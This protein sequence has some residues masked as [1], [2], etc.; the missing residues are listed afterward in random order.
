[1]TPLLDV[2]HLHVHFPHGHGLWGRV[3]RVT[4]AVDGV[5]LALAPGEIL[6]LVGE[7]GCGKSTFARAVLQLI[8]PTAG[9]VLYEGV[10]LVTLRGEALRRHRQALQMVFQDP[11]ASL[12]PRMRIGAIVSEPLR[13][14][15]LARG[16]AA[17]DRAAELLDLVGLPAN[18]LD[19]FPHEFSGGQRQRI[20]IAR[21]LATHP[22]VLFCDE[23]VSA[24]DVSIQAQVVNLIRDLQRRLGLTV[25]FI[26]H[27]LSV[28]RHLST[29]VAVM[30]LG[31]VVELAP[32]AELYAQPRHPYTQALLAAVPVPDPVVARTR[33][34][35]PLTGDPPSPEQERVG[36]DFAAR[37][38]LAQARCR[39]ERPALALLAPGHHVACFHAHPAAVAV[40]HQEHPTHG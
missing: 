28:V 1:M 25:V 20:A 34:P 12:N 40:A 7:S 37:C 10:D 9:Q 32:A 16:A 26:S 39:L 22:R 35:A 31:K 6:G 19:G 13:N 30:Y 23:P 24:L 36:C 17:R 38:P 21:A 2:R 15:G 27:D 18:A 4:R 11:Y 33:R 29:R 5:D 8:R 3:H 14:F